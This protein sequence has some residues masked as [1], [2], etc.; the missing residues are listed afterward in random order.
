M[1]LPPPGSG[2]GLVRHITDEDVLERELLFA[3]DT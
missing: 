2:Q 1:A 3:S